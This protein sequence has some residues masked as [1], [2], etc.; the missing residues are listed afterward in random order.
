MSDQAIEATIAELVDQCARAKLEKDR[1]AKV[2]NQARLAVERRMKEEEIKSFRADSGASAVL[3]EPK[4][5]FKLSSKD[6]EAQGKFIEYL[7]EIGEGHI[8]SRT[9]LSSSADA[10]INARI[11]SQGYGSI[12]T[13]IKQR[14]DF[15]ESLRIGTKGIENE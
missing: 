5:T 13:W 8:A 15:Y 3:A 1:T 11:D 10:W 12:P 2:Y 4:R 9:L 14:E 6:P 7:D